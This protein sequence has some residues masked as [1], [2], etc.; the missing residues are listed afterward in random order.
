M[1]KALKTCDLFS[2]SR[3]GHSSLSLHALG[4]GEGTLMQRMVDFRLRENGG[5]GGHQVGIPVHSEKY[6]HTGPRCLHAGALVGPWLDHRHKKTRGEK[7]KEINTQ[8]QKVKNFSLGF[9]L[10]DFPRFLQ[11]EP[12]SWKF[13]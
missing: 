10:T 11:I 3:L 6:K 13:L 9:L 12:L 8:Y 5:G 1:W 7:Y 2:S 4:S